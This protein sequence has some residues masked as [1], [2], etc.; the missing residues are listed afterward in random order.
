MKLSDQISFTSRDWVALKE[1]LNQELKNAVDRLCGD[2]STTDA[3][4]LRGKIAFIK[5]VL[6]EE[7]KHSQRTI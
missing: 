2:V 1:Y 4:K 5:Q 3:D 6:N 7:P